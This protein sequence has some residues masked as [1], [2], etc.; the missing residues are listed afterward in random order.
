MVGTQPVAGEAKTPPYAICLVRKSAGAAS[1]CLTEWINAG[2]N[3][4]G[5]WSRPE[6]IRIDPPIECS[7][8]GLWK[9]KNVEPIASGHNS[10]VI[11]G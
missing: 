2:I 11:C 5:F 6:G 4:R 9:K 8:T 7:P 3:H 10:R 1:V